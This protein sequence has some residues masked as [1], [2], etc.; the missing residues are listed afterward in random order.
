[1]MTPPPFSGERGCKK[2]REKEEKTSMVRSSCSRASFNP[3][4]R[5]RCEEDGQKYKVEDDD[6]EEEEAQR[7][8]KKKKKKRM[9]ATGR[10]GCGEGQIVQVYAVG[11]K[12]RRKKNAPH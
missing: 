8:K 3:R 4:S 9:G 2:N 12:E 1:M 10:C 7:V 6:D 5:R 11:P